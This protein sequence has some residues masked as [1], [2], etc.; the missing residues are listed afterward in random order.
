MTNTAALTAVL[1]Q[2][3]RVAPLRDDNGTTSPRPGQPACP[4]CSESFVPV[5]R[6]LY[7]STAC[8]K[9]AFRRRHATAAPVV[10]APAGPARRERT[11]YECGT[12][13]GRQLGQQRCSDCGTFGT[14]LGLG[15]H[16]P[17]CQEPIT[18]TDLD[19]NL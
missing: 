11:V 17:C 8:R 10:V 5:R 14:T 9:T 2:V 7:C 13:G 1:T 6:Q 3:A 19:L 12:C 4:V 15:G 16:C 18:L